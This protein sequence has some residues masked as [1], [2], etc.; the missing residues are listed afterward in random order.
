MR[1]P[2]CRGL[3][4]VVISAATV[5]C[6]FAQSTLETKSLDG[7]DRP[8]KQ[9]G[10]K[11]SSLSQ[12]LDRGQSRTMNAAPSKSSSKFVSLSTDDYCDQAVVRLK[13]RM[14]TRGMRYVNRC[15][16]LCQRAV[17]QK[18]V[19]F[20][21][22][23]QGVECNVMEI[24][25]DINNKVIDKRAGSSR[26]SRTA[27]AS[28]PAYQLPD[29]VVEAQP[30]PPDTRVDVNGGAV[31]V[32]ASAIESANPGSVTGDRTASVQ[33]SAVEQGISPSQTVDNTASRDNMTGISPS[34]TVPVDQ[35]SFTPM[36]TQTVDQASRTQ[37]PAADMSTRTD[38]VRI[39]ETVSLD[40][41]DNSGATRSTIM[42]DVA[43][44]DRSASVTNQAAPIDSGAAPRR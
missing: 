32:D 2:L 9:L 41:V 38:A 6:V 43:L 24:P 30:G 26:T 18:R 40:L 36:P 5:S 16:A 17:A 27:K 29:A 22:S 14:G 1:I 4:A 21:N 7:L 23:A 20:D 28:I 12:K 39:Q 31:N 10:G 34:Q 35:A 33:A 25:L 37:M 44:V 13:S 19:P 11:N 15:R 3:A 8:G 42:T